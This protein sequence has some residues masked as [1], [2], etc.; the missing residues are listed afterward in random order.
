[1]TKIYLEM[2]EVQMQDRLTREIAP[3][4]QNEISQADEMRCNHIK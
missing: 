1:M 4:P 2:T 3:L